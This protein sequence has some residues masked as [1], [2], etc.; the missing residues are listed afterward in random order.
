VKTGED[1]ITAV[2]EHAPGETILLNV[3]RRGQK[4]E[5]PVVLK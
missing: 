5:L 3:L 2:E 4:I 1:F